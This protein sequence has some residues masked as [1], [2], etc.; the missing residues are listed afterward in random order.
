MIAV[1]P[2]KAV[3]IVP[4]LEEGAYH[5]KVLGVFKLVGVIVV[6]PFKV[7]LPFLKEGASHVESF[8]SI[9][10]MICYCRCSV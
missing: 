6:V 1:V 7:V 10:S 8:R 5:C 2:F 9:E 3:V 4:F